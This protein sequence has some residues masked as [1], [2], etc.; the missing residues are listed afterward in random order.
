[1]NAIHKKALE[2][3]TQFKR[4]EADLIA[5]L[6]EVET[7]RVFEKLGF[8]S[9][10]NYCVQALGLS[11]SV[12]ANFI[13]VS[14]KAREIPVLQS[15]IRSGV[16][17]VSKAR[18]IT[19][20]LT[21]DNQDEWIEKA[22]LLPTRKLEEE[23]AQVAPREA[24]PERLKFVSAER[25]ELRVGIS[26]SLQEKLDRVRDLESQRTARAASLEDTLEAL[27]EVYL[28]TKDPMKR[29]ERVM[30]RK[31]EAPKNDA[32]AC[33]TVTHA[34]S[35]KPIPAIIRHRI[36]LRDGGQCAHVNERGER[37]E[38]RRWLDVHHIRPKNLGGENSLENLTTLCSAHH[39]AEHLGEMS[40]GVFRPKIGLRK[41][42]S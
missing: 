2:V 22:R 20:V 18:K 6:Q 35:R 41:L 38:N 7:A 24:V 11:E 42:R 36:Q 25:L 34:G 5:I 4:A 3:A 26:K 17:P 29:A 13:T 10:F 19:P 1:M 8:T 39:R 32:D 16:L 12:A 23:V 30:K 15:A 33:V 14:R 21:L 31:S 40:H 28:E 27:T 9:L 37:C